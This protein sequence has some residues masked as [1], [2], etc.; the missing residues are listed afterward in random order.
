[1]DGADPAQRLQDP[2]V[3]RFSF[4]G[5]LAGAA[6]LVFLVPLA[7]ALSGAYVVGAYLAPTVPL[8]VGQML[9]MLAG[10]AAG[11]GIAKLVL[12]LVRDK[13][14]TSGGGDE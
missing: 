7:T 5:A 13:Q 6:V 2:Q 10:L 3:R 8:G 9:G 14:T 4:G 1:M 11:V 12:R